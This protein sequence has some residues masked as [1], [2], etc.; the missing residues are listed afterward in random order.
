M[1]YFLRRKTS[2]E[3]NSEKSDGTH[4]NLQYNYAERKTDTNQE[5]LF[6]YGSNCNSRRTIEFFTSTSTEAEFMNVQ[7]R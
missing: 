1:Q 6:L 2:L 7:F 4:R 3:E 5:I